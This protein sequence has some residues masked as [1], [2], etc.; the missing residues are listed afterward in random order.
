MDT[1]HRPGKFRQHAWIRKHGQARHGTLPLVRLEELVERPTL[2]QVVHVSYPRDDLRA[3]EPVRRLKRGEDVALGQDGGAHGEACRSRPAPRV[4]ASRTL[5]AGVRGRDGRLA[6]EEVE[7]DVRPVL[8]AP[9]DTS[10]ARSL[11]SGGGITDLA[12][13][14]T[15]QRRGTESVGVNSASS[16]QQ[17]NHRDQH[18]GCRDHGSIHYIY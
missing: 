18:G 2:L 15:T 16:P 9:M 10:D 17:D 12:R 5:T 11:P 3:E 13:S 1:S 14:G 7:R 6:G 4:V 8:P